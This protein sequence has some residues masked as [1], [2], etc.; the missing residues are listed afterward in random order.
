MDSESKKCP[1]CAELIKIDANKCRY[2]G[3]WLHLQRKEK[4]RTSKAVKILVFIALM[5]ITYLGSTI[6]SAVGFSLWSAHSYD[7]KGLLRAYEDIQDLYESGEVGARAVYREYLHPTDRAK[8]TEEDY[9]K[10]YR[11]DLSQYPYSSQPQ[12]HGVTIDGNNGYIDRTANDCSDL[13]CSSILRTVRSYKHFSWENGRW[14]LHSL[15]A[16]CPRQEPDEMPP[17]FSRALSLVFQRTAEVSATEDK[18]VIELWGSIL[19]CIDVQYASSDQ[20][21]SDAEGIFSFIPGQ[22]AERLSIYVSPRYK[23]QDDLTTAMLLMHEYTHATNYVVGLAS[24]EPLDC[25]EE[26]AS[27]FDAEYWLLLH[28]NEGEK[29]SIISRLSGSSTPE[30]RDFAETLAAITAYRGTNFKEKALNYV[31]S[32][33]FYQR[34]CET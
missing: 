32:D 7:E 22:S 3:E 18:E 17:E 6:I 26:E 34:Q 8:E 27:A 10:F 13:S 29:Q 14:Y 30:L 5:V 11:E 28:L 33:P 12:I 2:C 21:M 15:D 16:L 23:A 24:G 9:I 1:H 4:K 31:K 19:N 20:E 25:F